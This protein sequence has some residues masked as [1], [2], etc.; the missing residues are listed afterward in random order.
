MALFGK[1]PSD[2]KHFVN[3][4]KNEYS[5]EFLLVKD[6]VEDFNF[7]STLIVAENEQALFVNNGVVE[8]VFDGGRYEL[9]TQNYPFITRL[10]TLVSGGVSGFHCQV[11]FVRTAD[12]H[13]IYWGT[14]TPI[15]LRDPVL[16]IPVEVQAR[17]AYR[18]RVVDSKK[19]FLKMVGNNEVYFLQE[20]FQRYLGSEFAGKI[21]SVIARGIKNSG[22]EVL[23]ICEM[24]DEFA[25]AISPSIAETFEE[26]GVKLVNF[27]IESLD[28][29][30]DSTYRQTIE[31]ANA[32]RI[33]MMQMGTA[34]NALEA[35]KIDQ[36]S[37]AQ[38]RA[39]EHLGDNWE[40]L[41]SAEILQSVAD[42]SGS[43][44]IASMGVGLGMGF[45]AGGTMN[46]MAQN[47]FGSQNPF[48]QVA[49]NAQAVA[50]GQAA[51]NPQAAAGQPAQGSQPAPA[52]QPTQGTQSVSTEQS[53]QGSESVAAE[54]PAQSAEAPSMVD[55]PSCGAA[56]PKT[57]KFCP[58]CGAKMAV[59]AFCASCGAELP[60]SG[61]FCP[62]CGTERG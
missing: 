47:M 37:A 29:P 31:T 9:E 58:E 4:I 52:E 43:D 18:I 19:F 24:Q 61:K 34:E 15:Q 26:Y 16:G 39:F 3:V 32:N 44:G 1:G 38:A 50:G 8:Q 14:Q 17:G 33:A 40:R 49:Q 5:G 53:A 45:A 62:E 41:K 12:S 59:A 7:G 46:Q 60:A 57:S 55:C 20:E 51:Q 56:V 21:K 23:G 28:V 6:P 10:R 11:Y 36:V 25:Q 2:K 27:S 13:Q 35:D 30:M 48:G 42:H 22:Q 54:P